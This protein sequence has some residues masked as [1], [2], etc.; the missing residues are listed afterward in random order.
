MTAE[1]AQ[2]HTR[3][4]T[5]SVLW[6]DDAIESF[7]AMASDAL[8]THGARLVP[9]ATI[10]VALE[11]IRRGDHYGTLLVDLDLGTD[12]SGIDFL[13]M[14][15]VRDFIILHAPRIFTVSYHIK[16]R[17]FGPRLKEL[18][19]RLDFREIEI[20]HP[21]FESRESFSTLFIPRLELRI[22]D[23]QPSDEHNPALSLSLRMYESLSLRGK[24][25][26]A[27]AANLEAKDLLDAE[28]AAGYSWILFCGP[29]PRI[30][31]KSLSVSDAWTDKQIRD[32]AARI[33]RPCFQLAFVPQPEECVG[34]DLEGYPTVTLR[35]EEGGKAIEQSFHFDT[36]ASHSFMSF[37][38]LEA[39]GLVS[40]AASPGPVNRVNN[41]G[42]TIATDYGFK[43]AID[44]DF[45]CQDFG[46]DE[47]PIV[48]K[49]W[50]IVQWIDTSY[51]RKCA[52]AGC[53]DQERIEQDLP[54]KNRAGLIGRNLLPDNGISIVLDG[55]SGMTR[56][57]R[58]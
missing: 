39:A 10:D 32:H 22:S 50:T 33:E 43:V 1:Q 28:V 14:P 47:T 38:E 24:I 58:E 25:A 56:L 52:L 36:G 16:S 19:D 15:D 51:C 46:N 29:E 9:A 20:L 2:K 41:V 3:T 45:I 6:L 13:E 54:C 26:A 37:E 42:E 53:D 40:D 31:D 8:A 49:C 5:E 18:H 57:P 30:I 21:E 12:V 7:A 11:R 23:E 17:K 34:G 48:L 55:E 4:D 27:E 44:G 35:L